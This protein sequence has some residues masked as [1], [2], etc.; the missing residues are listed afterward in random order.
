MKKFLE[1]WRKFLVEETEYEGILKLS[2]DERDLVE[3]EVLQAMLPEDAIRLVPEDLH[4][5]LVHQS[6]LK[7][8]ED[9]LKSLDFPPAPAL[10]LD[11]QVF[12][13]QSPGKKSWAVRLANQ[14]EMR[15]YVKYIME[16]L[17]SQNTNPEPERVF[18]ISLANLTGNPKDS[19]R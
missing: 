18:H 7:P 8:F 13:R 15:D 11:D 17:G 12:L 6:I 5:T 16:L 3:L 10:S 2:P 9:K 14:D 1:E 19:V 4:V